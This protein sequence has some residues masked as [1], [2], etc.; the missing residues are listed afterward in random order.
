MVGTFTICRQK[1]QEKARA[2]GKGVFVAVYMGK[3]NRWA[4]ASIGSNRNHHSTNPCRQSGT[5]MPSREC[6]FPAKGKTVNA[7]N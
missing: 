7:D 4:D 2:V 3:L 6:S 5:N 1:A